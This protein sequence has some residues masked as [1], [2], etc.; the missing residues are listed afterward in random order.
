LSEA[1]KASDD[2]VRW[3]PLQD[4]RCRDRTTDDNPVKNR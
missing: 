3:H 2:H 1:E 4:I